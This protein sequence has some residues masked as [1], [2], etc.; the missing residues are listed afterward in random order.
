MCTKISLECSNTQAKSL[1][2]G[3]PSAQIAVAFNEKNFK[4]QK[5]FLDK[6][7]VH[8]CSYCFKF[9]LLLLL[10][11]SNGCDYNYKT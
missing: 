10:P 4:L 9:Q 1:P 8:M 11:L 7:A 2:L 5:H 6:V 3:K